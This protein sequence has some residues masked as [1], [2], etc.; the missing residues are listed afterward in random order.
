MSK[1]EVVVEME[2]RLHGQD[3]CFDLSSDDSDD[4]NY[5]PQEWLTSSDP[6]RTIIGETNRK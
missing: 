5:S 6:S 3:V 1:P 2:S 4:D